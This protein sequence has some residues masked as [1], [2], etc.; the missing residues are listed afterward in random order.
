MG[1]RD[2]TGAGERG[3]M[4]KLFDVRLLMASQKMELEH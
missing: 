3:L 1:M 2:E 4:S